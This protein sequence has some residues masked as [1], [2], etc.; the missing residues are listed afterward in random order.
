[1]PAPGRRPSGAR[2]GR[3][4]LPGSSPSTSVFDALRKI[5]EDLV[6]LFLREAAGLDGGGDVLL[7]RVGHRLTE[8][9]DRLALGARDL[10]ERVAAL[11]PLAQL[12]VGQAEVGGAS[13]AAEVNDPVVVARA[14][15]ERA[16][17]RRALG[18]EPLLEESA[19]SCVRS[20]A[21][22]AASILAS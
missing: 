3:A 21:A 4:A 7:R 8:A 20:P 19:C 22:T 14:V 15:E 17:Q 18:L 1:M 6:G 12:V 10:G 5:G 11:E 9:V 16:E 2:E 13:S